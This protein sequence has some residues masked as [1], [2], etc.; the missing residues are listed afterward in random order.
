[1]VSGNNS[2]K[3]EIASLE[4]DLKLLI[5]AELEGSKIC[6]GSRWF[7]RGEK[8]TYFFFQLKR[9]RSSRGFIPSILNSDD[10]EVFTRQEIKQADVSIY[11]LLLLEDF[12][13][14][15]VDSFFETA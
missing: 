10:V 14:Y 11:S 12:K 1:M 8:P 7:E 3:A 4:L 9:E 5:S 13:R 2:V 6:S 15:S